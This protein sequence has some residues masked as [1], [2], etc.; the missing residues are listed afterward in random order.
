M[1]RG[2]ITV[3]FGGAALLAAGAAGL[4]WFQEKT[5]PVAF[6]EGAVQVIAYEAG[7]LF[8]KDP[9]ATPDEVARMIKSLH[10]ASVINIK[11]ASDGE[12]VDQFGTAF[13][14]ERRGG[15]GKSFITVTSAGPD[16]EF[17]TPDDIGFKHEMDTAP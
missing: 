4:W 10:A 11:I 8:E 7:D 9:D 2:I 3:L 17:G 15:A 1:R 5:L 14:V 6:T 16:G 12:V 13:Q